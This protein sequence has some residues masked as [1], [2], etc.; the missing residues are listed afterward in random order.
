[1]S[2]ATVDGIKA[3]QRYTVIRQSYVHDMRLVLPATR[4]QGGGEKRTM[5]PIQILKR[6]RHQPIDGKQPLA[7]GRQGI[8]NSA[9]QITQDFGS[10]PANVT[11]TDNWGGLRRLHVQLRATKSAAA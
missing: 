11:I 5:M 9:I 8:R 10:H 1:M 7:H 2:T 4:N 3:D 6:Q